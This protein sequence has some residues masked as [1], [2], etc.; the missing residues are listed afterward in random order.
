MGWWGVS[1]QGHKI[2]SR[3]GSPDC[4]IPS[5][6]LEWSR[7]SARVVLLFGYGQLLCIRPSQT[8]L[9]WCIGPWLSTSAIC[10]TARRRVSS[11]SCSELFKRTEHSRSVYLSRTESTNTKRSKSPSTRMLASR[12]Y[13]KS[14]LEK[15]WSVVAERN[16]L[17]S[18]PGGPQWGDRI[19]IA[20]RTMIPRAQDVAH[21]LKTRFP[22]TQPA[23][24]ATKHRLA[25]FRFPV[26][27]KESR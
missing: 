11:I 7:P 17:P 1:L 23:T 9:F 4:S 3:A 12:P 16:T 24:P 10:W 6:A 27:N 18:D 21:F 8:A 15:V 26:S 2:Q 5:S 13:R 20:L 25:S 19:R 22:S 14:L